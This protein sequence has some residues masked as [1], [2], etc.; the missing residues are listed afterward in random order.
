[1]DDESLIITFIDQD[2]KEHNLRFINQT[3]IQDTE[4][5]ATIYVK[6][7][8]DD[9][10]GFRSESRM[11]FYPMKTLSDDGFIQFKTSEEDVYVMK[12]R[13]PDFCTSDGFYD[14]FMTDY[15]YILSDIESNKEIEIAVKEK[16]T[17]NSFSIVKDTNMYTLLTDNDP[18]SQYG[19]YK[20]CRFQKTK[21]N[22]Y[23]VKV[24]IP[25]DEYDDEVECKNCGILFHER[26]TSDD[27]DDNQLCL[28]CERNLKKWFFLARDVNKL[29]IKNET[30]FEVLITGSINGHGVTLPGTYTAQF[31]NPYPCVSMNRIGIADLR[32]GLGI[33]TPITQGNRLNLNIKQIMSNN[34]GNTKSFMTNCLIW[35]NNVNKVGEKEE[36]RM[37][38]AQLSKI[39]PRLTQQQREEEIQKIKDRA[40]KR[41]EK[42]NQDILVNLEIGVGTHPEIIRSDK[43]V[44]GYDTN[45]Y[46]GR[47][48]NNIV[49]MHPSVIPNE[50]SIQNGGTFTGVACTV[51]DKQTQQSFGFDYNEVIQLAPGGERMDSIYQKILYNVTKICIPHIL[52]QANSQWVPERANLLGQCL[53]NSNLCATYGS[54][55]NICIID[56]T[57]SPGDP[58]T[59][60]LGEAFSS[61]EKAM[62]LAQR[63][64]EYASKV[65]RPDL[66]ETVNSMKTHLSSITGIT[67]DQADK[68]FTALV[69]KYGNDKLPKIT[70][71]E[72]RDIAQSA[73]NIQ[74]M[75]GITL[76]QAIYTVLKFIP[77]E[78]YNDITEKTYIDFV[79]R[80]SLI[81]IQQQPEQKQQQ[82]DDIQKII[83]DLE[84]SGITNVTQDVAID[85]LNRVPKD[86]QTQR[87]KEAIEI[88]K[89][90]YY[91]NQAINQVMNRARVD[92]ETAQTAI[93]IVPGTYSGKVE[94]AITLINEARIVQQTLK[95]SYGIDTDINTIF[96]PLLNLNYDT[97]KTINLMVFS[98]INSVTN[99]EAYQF[100]NNANWDQEMAESNLE[101]QRKLEAESNFAN[102]GGKRSKKSRKNKNPAYFKKSRKRNKPKKSRKTNKPKKSKKRVNTK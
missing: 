10:A 51:Y 95:K 5:D 43:V 28:T 75:T 16:L 44:T 39:D 80:N 61:S 49:L 53:N 69:N 87:V 29:Q 64:M 22:V 83:S 7:F 60:V 93:D 11:K 2:K 65:Y 46:S 67:Q 98:D 19:Q 101:A 41:I 9:V 78:D 21:K 81:F 17:E 85:A 59:F 100:L 20:T 68:I 56:G 45:E 82:P 54:A 96:R 26:A 14:I 1:M 12:D 3:V 36:F 42:T 90:D 79:V 6:E 55:L 37:A 77:G 48:K 18:E 91:R 27:D 74:Q 30:P 34:I 23:R 50:G 88:I 86:K 66:I 94:E 52:Q 24:T 73:K 58:T 84:R 31:V 32:Y 4:T 92:K 99:R 71:A 76:D 62:A 38:N 35:Y 72:A 13:H 47:V 102:K 8:I 40:F 57:C 70:I 97:Q 63:Q 25:M 15:S 89:H 33:L